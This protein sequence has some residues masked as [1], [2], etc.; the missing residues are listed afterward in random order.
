V[1]VKQCSRTL[2]HI[3]HQL[4]YSKKWRIWFLFGGSI[5][6]FV[7]CLLLG[8]TVET[9][10]TSVPITAHDYSV[11]SGSRIGN[12]TAASAADI[13]TVVMPRKSS[14]KIAILLYY[15]CRAENFSIH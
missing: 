7:S 9:G 10:R 12:A 13:K 14:P 15:A 5:Q 2:E 1:K 3:I 6:Q 8:S 11:G 4:K